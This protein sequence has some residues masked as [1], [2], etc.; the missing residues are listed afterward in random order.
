[1]G[2]PQARR[3][4]HPQGG[5]LSLNPFPIIYSRF[6]FHPYPFLLFL[7]I[8]NFVQRGNTYAAKSSDAGKNA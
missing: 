7:T 5:L 4:R 2:G 6:G 8:A 1:M 3:Q